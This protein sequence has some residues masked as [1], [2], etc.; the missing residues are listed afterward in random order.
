MA[1]AAA[2]VKTTGEP[3]SVLT[4]GSGTAAM[5]AIDFGAAVTGACAAWRRDSAVIGSSARPQRAWSAAGY[6]IA[7]S[8]ARSARATA[9]TTAPLSSCWR[10]TIASRKIMKVACGTCRPTGGRTGR[11]RVG[12]NGGDIA[13]FGE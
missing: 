10:I 9:A 3:S 4:G 5:G 11:R 12:R 2:A 13:S 6:R 8:S 1:R 7:A